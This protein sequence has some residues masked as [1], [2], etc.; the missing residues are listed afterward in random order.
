MNTVDCHNICN[1]HPKCTITVYRIFL[2]ISVH[3][4]S[5][6][7]RKKS[8]CK[9]QTHGLNRL[10]GKYQAYQPVQDAQ[11]TICIESAVSGRKTCWCRLVSLP[12]PHRIFTLQRLD[13]LILSTTKFLRIFSRFTIFLVS[14]FKY[15]RR[16]RHYLTQDK[17]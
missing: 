3:L 4:I 16:K 9:I 15:K 17:L 6:F 5:V 8:Y 14:F 12:L 1:P 2:K 10:L 7:N 13:L 11:R